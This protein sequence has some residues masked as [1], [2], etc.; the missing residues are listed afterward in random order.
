MTTEHNTWTSH[1]A[2]TRW[3]NRLTGRGDVATFAVTDEARD[4][5]AGPAAE[6]AEVLV[7]GVDV[8]GVGAPRPAGERS[9]VRAE[10]GLADD[11]LVVVTVAN[12]REQ[13]DYPNLLA[14]AATLVEQ[15]VRF[16]L[17][18][19]G[20][21]PL[22]AEVQARRD[23]LGLQDHVVL[24]GFRADAVAV[25]A[26]A[27]VFVL[28][29]A[30]EGLPV[31]VME[32]AALGLPIVATRVGGVAEALD[33]DHAILV[34]PR[35]PDALAA[36]LRAV[37]EDADRRAELSAA[38]RSLAGRFDIARATATVTSTYER[39]C[40]PARLRRTA[41][42]QTRKPR[43]AAAEVREATADDR[44]PIIALLGASLGWEDDERYQALYAWKHETNPFG[45]SPAW[46]VD[47]AGEVV[48]VRLFMRWAFIR[49]GRT[50]RAVR[51]VDTATHPDHQGRGLFTALTL[52]AL[53]A[54]RA[55]GV[56]LVFN[57]PNEQS[58]PGYLKMGW[59]E[60]GRLP[61]ATRPRSPAQLVTVARSRTPAERWSLPL[62]I[63]TAVDEWVDDGG[64]AR[65]RPAAVVSNTDRRLVTATS[66]AFVRWRYGLAPL[67][68][69]VVDDGVGAVVVRLRRRGPATELV[70]A[71]RLGDPRRADRLAAEAMAE[72]GASHALRL[73]PPDVRTG[74]LPL[75]G[76]GPILTWRGVT[77]GGLPPLPNWR[78]QLRDIELF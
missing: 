54:A 31:A 68:Y 73:G 56:D 20:Q 40:S 75:P 22:E 42:E 48:A 14:A 72:A 23:A 37:L 55:D 58:R 65:H 76:G 77:D 21:G 17:V 13:K 18:A 28:A 32:A 38:S 19:V 41:N 35:D 59:R 62:E 78:L 34:P 15:G 7:H 24:A 29:S 46:V 70:V 60:V 4:S 39:V 5:M 30:W 47:D 44:D 3:A 61:A 45:P 63:G 43:R 66:E 6:R 50:V 8:A 10:L 2:A 71:E 69:R 64:W 52:R 1:R 53:E 11:E 12:L 51:A 74:F 27:D 25:M 9:R 67:H 16:R 57:T 49:G 26:A 33:D 36:G